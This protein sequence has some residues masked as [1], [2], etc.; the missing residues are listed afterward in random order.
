MQ[1]SARNE[2]RGVFGKRFETPFPR[3]L[4]AVQLQSVLADGNLA[5]DC[6][7]EQRKYLKL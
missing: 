3:F 4:P 7:W 1:D 5:S 6:C 2:Y